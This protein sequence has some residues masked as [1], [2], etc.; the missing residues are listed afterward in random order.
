MDSRFLPV[1]RTGPLPAR[2]I[3]V[4]SQV[5]LGTW[6]ELFLPD[7]TSPRDGIEL[8]EHFA[9][10][11]HEGD[12]AWLTSLAQT[13]VEAMQGAVMADCRQGGEVEG[14]ADHATPAADGTIAALLSAIARPRCETYQRG[15]GLTGEVTQLG[16][17]GSEDGSSEFTDTAHATQQLCALAQVLAAL[18]RRFVLVVEPFNFLV[19]PADMACGG[20]LDCGGETFVQTVQFLHPLCHELL[21]TL[22]H[23][24][25]KVAVR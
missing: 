3:C 24:S 9:H 13:L 6:Y 23:I 21:A 25:Q 5:I 1:L 12:L 7:G 2:S 22:Q 17:I 4:R 20:T 18:H 15:Q 19:Q 16:Q 14:A 11:C 10:D 8:Q